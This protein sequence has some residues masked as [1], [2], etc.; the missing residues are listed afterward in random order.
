[1]RAEDLGRGPLTCPETHFAGPCGTW[2]GLGS[3]KACEIARQLPALGT[4]EGIGAG[5]LPSPPCPLPSIQGA[6]AWGCLP[7]LRC[8]ERSLQGGATSSAPSEG[9]C[10]PASARQN[11][12]LPRARPAAASAEKLSQPP[13]APHLLASTGLPLGQGR[14]GLDSAASVTATATACAPI[15]A[16]PVYGHLEPS[17]QHRVSGWGAA[18]RSQTRPARS[19]GRCPQPLTQPHLAQGPALRTDGRTPWRMSSEAAV[20]QLRTSESD[21]T[22]D[23]KMDEASA[24]PRAGQTEVA[25]P[26]WSWTVPGWGP[27][28]GKAPRGAAQA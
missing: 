10:S 15:R 12:L 4:D 5:G 19:Q 27:H 1:M 9:P 24:P 6:E 26:L 18:G 13:G 14:P 17:T 23:I 22:A 28:P 8:G 11:C 3:G 2:E 16:H 25:T 20:E 21:P 7:P